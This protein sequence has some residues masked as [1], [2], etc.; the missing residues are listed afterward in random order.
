MRVTRLLVV[1]CVAAAAVGCGGKVIHLGDGNDG[2]PCAHGQV[3]A[4]EVLWIG[5]SWILV[6]GGQ[7]TRVQDLARAAG[8]IGPNDTYVVGAVAATTMAQIAGQYDAQEA[9]STKVKVLI[10]DGG[11]WDTIQA[12]LAGTSVQDAANGAATAFTQHLAKVASDGT[13]Q[14]VIYFLPPKLQMITG[15]AEVGALMQPACMQSKVPCHFLDLQPLWANPTAY[16]MSNGI[17]PTDAGAIVLG[18]AIWALMQQN[19]IA[20]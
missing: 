5:D 14:H 6:P 3:N 20:Q 17:L 18:D 15:V 10:E 1:I 19:C 16:T 8:A 4:N 2:G 13:V 11:T 7:V 9:G 12:G